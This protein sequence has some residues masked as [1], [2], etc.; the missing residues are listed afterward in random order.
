MTTPC[1]DDNTILAFIEG[2]VDDVVRAR[3]DGH[4]ES[5]GDCRRLLSAVAAGL[6]T[7]AAPLIEALEDDDEQPTAQVAMP[8]SSLVGE[9]PIPPLPR[10]RRQSQPLFQ[11]GEA[12]DHFRVLRLIGRGGMGEVYLARD[13]RLGRKV[14]L[15]AIVQS[16]LTVTRELFLREA[17]TTARL[18]H[19]HVI[20]IFD[21][22]EHAG[23]PYVALEYLEG[24]SLRARLRERRLAPRDAMRM[25]IA[26]AEA[27]HHAHQHGIVHRDLKPENV[28]LPMDGRLRVL[29]FGISR[30]V[31]EHRGREHRHVTDLQAAT[32]SKDA[33]SGTPAYM[34]PEQWRGDVDTPALDVWALG[35]VLFEMLAG[36]RPY[37]TMNPVVLA[38]QVVDPTA[39]PALDDDTAPAEVRALVARCLSKEPTQRPSADDVARALQALVHGSAP[40]R[41]DVSP[42]RGLLAFEEG[43]ADLFFGR[44]DEV[45]AF[46]ERLRTRPLLPIVGPSGRGK[47]SFVAAGVIPRL[48]ERERWRVVQLRP[49]AAPLRAL[50]IALV[51]E[52]RR[53]PGFGGPSPDSTAVTDERAADDDKPG[54]KAPS[55]L[56]PAAV[57]A[58]L[59]RTPALF[60][61]WLQ[62]L[63]RWGRE[64]VLVVVDQLE[65]VYTAGAPPAEQVAFVQALAEAAD[66]A[67]EPWRIVFTLRDDFLGQLADGLGAARALPNVTVLRALDKAALKRALER[68]LAAVGYGVDDVTLLDDIVAACWDGAASSGG[69]LPVLQFTAQLLWERRDVDARLIRRRAYVELGG[70]AGALATHADTFLKGLTPAETQ[71]LRTMMLRLITEQRTRRRRPRSEVIGGLAQHE[72]LLARLVESRLVT[73][74]RG[75]AGAD[76]DVEIVHESIIKSWPQLA[77]WVDEGRDDIAFFAEVSQAAAL[78]VRRGRLASEVWSGEP[79][80]LAV[81]RLADNGNSDVRAFLTAGQRSEQKARRRR[82][83]AVAVLALGLVGLTLTSAALAAVFAD[84][85]ARAVAERVEAQV[86]S[87]RAAST[88]GDASAA[89]GLVR[90]ALESGD[91]LGARAQWWALQQDPVVASVDEALIVQHLSV[92]ADGRFITTSADHPWIRNA[93]SLVGVVRGAWMS[94]V[95][96]EHM[97]FSLDGRFLAAGSE[98]LSVIDTTTGSNDERMPTSARISSLAAAPDGAGLVVGTDEGRVLEVSWQGPRGERELLQLGERIEQVGFVGA[99]AVPTAGAVVVVVTRGAGLQVWRLGAVPALLWT[100]A[101][102]TPIRRL[103]VSPDRRRAAIGTTSGKVTLLDLEGHAALWSVELGDAPVA[104]LTLAGRHVAAVLHQRNKVALL[105]VDDGGL[106]ALIDEPEV[107][108]VALSPDGA[109]LFTGGMDHRLRKRSVD[110]LVQRQTPGHRGPIID[111]AWS[112]DGS[113]IASVGA[114]GGLY[115]WDTATGEKRS[116]TFLRKTQLNDVAWS[117]DSALLAVGGFDGTVFLV[118]ATLHDPPRELS[119]KSLNNVRNVV[120]SA[121]G[122]S[123]LAHGGDGELWLADTTTGQ[124]QRRAHGGSGGVDGWALGAGP[125]HYVHAAPGQ[126]LLWRRWADDVVDKTIAVPFGITYG[127]DVS[128]DESTIFLG[129]SAGQVLKV[130]AQS[131]AHVVVIETGKRVYRVDYEPQRGLLAAPLTSGNVVV[132]DLAS[133]EQRQLRGH[134]EEVYSVHF[135]AAGKRLAS[136]GFDG[137]VR[138]WDVDAGRPLWLGLAFQEDP[139]S[140]W[141]HRGWAGASSASSSSSAARA[142]RKVIEQRAI[143]AEVSLDGG[144]SCVVTADERLELW[145]LQTDTRV[146]ELPAKAVQSVRALPN[147]CALLD[148]DGVFVIDPSGRELARVSGARAVDVDERWVYVGHGEAVRVLGHGGNEVARLSAR[149]VVSSARAHGDS[150]LIGYVTGDVVLHHFDGPMQGEVHLDDGLQMVG[151]VAEP[152][153]S[154]RHFE[155]FGIV[156]AGYVGGELMAWRADTGQKIFSERLRGRVEHFAFEG[157]QLR[158]LT[159]LGDVRSFDASALTADYCALLSKLWLEVPVV[160]NR[161]R[162]EERAP[163][164]Q[165]PC[166]KRSAP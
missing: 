78:W 7:R 36:K 63:A 52:Q 100:F 95:F 155:S 91:T 14:A 133:G 83:T 2:A 145:D 131:G 88:I 85:E 20:T 10:E 128:P 110:V 161:G 24:T 158:A 140:A 138:L 92:S 9:P 118:D 18:S 41:V 11:P 96:K 30:F 90:S 57:E 115:T 121:D 58:D 62:D 97:T 154:A 54:W 47:S 150:V 114:D 106:V 46:L 48:R 86:E 101:S 112:P 132:V 17:E 37:E 151:T 33:V 74:E 12:I 89:R 163:P 53:H 39:C 66:D 1:P 123:V 65:E 59:L 157:S 122:K 105:H 113:R 64:K 28:F 6:S 27:L 70:V 60:A 75:D 79:L 40:T 69:A 108:S 67:D 143:R 102:P 141:T 77:R 144:F 130:D 103:A 137:S 152:V 73:V 165:H 162:V 32:A 15:K 166:S 120:F 149:G 26:M 124:V 119:D 35:V 142:W 107:A 116:S 81:R 99:A 126:H 61:L 42:F 68:P 159:A 136:G 8:P 109:W 72:R 4:L 135:D 98:G 21:V 55:L 160:W 56:D 38:V 50:A 3:V 22:G 45:D 31:T 129:S 34:A 43:H 76:P 93:H 5:C 51:A 19:P 148:D 87:A 156:A 82:R 104:S 29:D 71:A 80:A 13:A 147:G 84:K 23:T 16:N 125:T 117:P 139:F 44:E 94:A 164:K 153:S 127:I 25:G 49:G 111:V 134:Y 146:A